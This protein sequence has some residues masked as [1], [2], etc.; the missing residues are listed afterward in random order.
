MSSAAQVL[1]NRQN[2][3]RSTGP[4]TAA[5]KAASSA[6]STRHGLTSKQIVIPGEDPVQ[7]DA[8]RQSLIKEHKPATETERTLVEELAASSWRLVRARRF[9]TAVLSKLIGDAEDPEAAF[10]A[11][12]LEEKPKELD[13]L[14]RYVTTIERAYYRALNKLAAIQKERKESQKENAIIQ[15]WVA[16]PSEPVHPEPSIGFVSKSATSTP[17]SALNRARQLAELKADS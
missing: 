17:P 8:H 4:V 2:S 12:F 6:N 13:R 15:A 11:M 3:L 14:Q 10:A 1:A 5:G 16:Q 9:E 7:Y